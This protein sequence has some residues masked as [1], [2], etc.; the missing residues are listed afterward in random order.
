[1]VIENHNDWKEPTL[2]K[3]QEK[4][5]VDYGNVARILRN[6]IDIRSDVNEYLCAY[7][8]YKIK[9][10]AAADVSLGD[11]ADYAVDEDEIVGEALRNVASLTD[12]SKLCEAIGKLDVESLE[13]YLSSGPVLT[14]PLNGS[15]FTPEG[16]SALALRILD[17]KPGEHLVDYGSGVGGFLELASHACSDIH[18]EGVDIDRDAIAVALIRSRFTGSSIGYASDDMFSFFDRCIGYCG[19]DKAFSNYPWGVRTKGIRSTSAYI[20]RV[21]Q[22]L[23][24]YG[25]PASAEW[26]FNRLL[27]DSINPVTG[28][29]V[30]ITGNGSLFSEVD[31]RVRKYFVE[32]GWVRAVVSLPEGIFFPWSSTKTSLIVFG[33]GSSGAVRFVD[34]SDLGTKG[35]RGAVFGP[36]AIDEVMRRLVADGKG[37]VLVSVAEIANCNYSLQPERY[38]KKEIVVENPIAIEEIAVSIR[39]GVSIGASALDKIACPEDTGMSYLNLSDIED[40]AIEGGHLN[41]DAIEKK[42]EKHCVVAGDLLVSKASPYKV[43]VAE[44]PEGKKVLACGNLYIVRFDTRKVDP[45][46]VAAFLSSS[47]GTELLSRASRGTTLRALSLGEFRRIPIPFADIKSQRRIGSVYRAKVDE[48][49][50]LKMR[51]ERARGELTDLFDKES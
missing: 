23:P 24:E 32:N 30:A 50:I 18:L 11:V 1:M 49:G 46:Y 7:L 34:A 9:M 22:G 16:I 25:R 2:A 39:R 29:A 48:I 42:Q 44:V 6:A 33:G 13:T 5:A 15:S 21:L 45:Y 38:F 20:G 4:R 47:R 31:S 14:F 26:V 35:R 28:M 27:V 12:S 36:D 37:S 40:G 19:A 17:V 8:A 51:L 43:A 41:I 3:A 10:E